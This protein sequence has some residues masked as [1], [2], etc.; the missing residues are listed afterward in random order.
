M[1]RIRNRIIER[2]RIGERERLK[3]NPKPKHTPTL[4]FA[5]YL[6]NEKENGFRE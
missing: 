6:R 2:N 1:K 4:V 5:K 3:I